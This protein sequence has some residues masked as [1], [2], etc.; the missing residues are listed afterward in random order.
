MGL[1][2]RFNTISPLS[3]GFYGGAPGAQYRRQEEAYGQALRLLRREARRGDAG[4]ALAEIKVRDQAMESGFSP[5]G[6]QSA[7]GRLKGA[8][9]FASAFAKRAAARNEAADIREQRNREERAALGA[10]G[11]AG[12]DGLG[13]GAG[14]TGLAPGASGAMLG[15][16]ARLG[17]SRFGGG[18]RTGGLRTG[19]V[20][21]PVRRLGESPGYGRPV[22]PGQGNEDEELKSVLGSRRKLLLG[23]DEELGSLSRFRS[24]LLSAGTGRSGW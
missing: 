19:S 22:Q 3:K 12:F 16:E 7:E 21:D 9:G 1:L 10:Q 8:Q 14:G 2:D 11:M 4:S 20:A 13:G 17:E 5:G 15:G 18:L 23:E 6:I 24:R